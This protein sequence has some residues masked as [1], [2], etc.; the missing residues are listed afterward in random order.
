VSIAVADHVPEGEAARSHDVRNSLAA[1]RLLVEGVRDGVIEATQESGM[2]DQMLLH[3][4][5]LSELLDGGSHRHEAREGASIVRPV[6]IGPL[7]EQWSAAM[8]P[9][10]RARGIELRCVAATGLPDIDC[11]AVQVGRVLLNL[12]DNAI[13]HTPVGG[14]IVVRVIAHPGGVQVQV[15][16]TGPGLPAAVRTALLEAPWSATLPGRSGSLG[17]VIA[18]TIVEAHG[19]S[20]WAGSPARGASVRFYLPAT[21]RVGA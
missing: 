5:L 11:R 7:I 4:R 8:R 10:S 19:G 14:I 1:L 6:A 15:D 12:I 3:V 17:L 16:D 20:L 2:L 9:A 13:R 18:R 21:A